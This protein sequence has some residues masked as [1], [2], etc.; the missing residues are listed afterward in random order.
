MRF[1]YYIIAITLCASMVAAAVDVFQNTHFDVEANQAID[2]GA[3]GLGGLLTDINTST[4]VP[5]V[6][7]SS[8]WFQKFDKIIVDAIFLEKDGDPISGGI[9]NIS[10]RDANFT[11][12]VV[13]ASMEE[14]QIAGVPHYTYNQSNISALGGETE[15]KFVGHVRC[16]KPGK[17][18]VFTEADFEVHEISVSATVNNTEVLNDIQST[19][20]LLRDM[21]DRQSEFA[22]EEVFLV[23]DAFNSMTDILEAVQSGEMSEGQ[24]YEQY[25]HVR[26]RLDTQM[27]GRWRQKQATLTPKAGVTDIQAFF[28]ARPRWLAGWSVEGVLYSFIAVLLIGIYYM[29]RKRDDFEELW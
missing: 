14:A 27:G 22:Q 25:R 26:S 21:L 12:L 11:T 18:S 5:S 9:C 29:R 3:E 7:I 13:N 2:P 1:L 20:T 23:T 24:A 19:R 16:N 15:G 6:H 10:L 28:T 8:T 17:R 4:S